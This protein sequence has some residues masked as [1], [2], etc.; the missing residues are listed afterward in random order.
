[1]YHEASREGI[2]VE[3]VAKG[4]DSPLQRSPV[5]RFDEVKKRKR[6]FLIDEML[7]QG[8]ALKCQMRPF[9]YP[10]RFD[11]QVDEAVVHAERQI[12]STTGPPVKFF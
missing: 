8:I 3:I 12:N 9:E 6:S 5:R 7:R 11:R 4:A 10:G 2:V 1:M